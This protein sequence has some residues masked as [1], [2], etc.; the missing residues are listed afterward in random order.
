MTT[1]AWKTPFWPEGVARTISDYHYPLARILDNTA[2]KYPE[3]TFT[4]F[5]GKARTYAQAKDTANRVANFLAR[6]GIRKGDRVALFLP[7]IPQ[8]PEIFFGILKVGAVC[9]NC[10]P[11]YTAAELNH[12]LGDSGARMI[13]CMDHPTLYDTA[14]AAID[15]TDVETV[16]I[17][18]IKSYLPSAQ[19]FIGGLL[20]KIP[21]ASTH[22]PG[23]LNFDDIVA[24][25]APTPPLVD[26]DPEKDTAVMLYTGGTTGTPKGAELT[27]TNF[28]YDL[29]AAHEFFQIDHG[30]GESPEPFRPGGEHTIVGVL[31][32][33]HSFGLTGAMLFAVFSGNKLICIPD[34]RAGKPAFTGLLK[35]VVKHKPTFMPGVPTLFVAITNHP[36]LKKYDL[37]TIKACISAGAP[38]PP[39]VCR[40]FEEKTGAVLFEVY[41][42]TETAPCVTSNPATKE[43]RKVGSI[44]FPI[45]GTDV[46]IVDIDTGT[47]ILPPGEEGELAVCGP[48]VMKG[49]WKRPDANA[50]TFKTL[51]GK[52]YFLTGDI[53]RID[54]NGYIS[55]TDRKKDMIIVSGFN[56]YPREIEDILYT[57][58]GVALAA[59][60]GVPD[61]T[62]G[63][64]V[65]AFIK[66][67]PEHIATQE[68][69]IL[70]CKDKMA[71]YKRPRIVE[72]TDDIPVSSVGKV[73]RRALKEKKQPCSPLD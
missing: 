40:Q 7:N 22:L 25:A 30:Q 48:Q 65:K 37:S 69:I 27:H 35:A 18:N 52:R 63:E 68:E 36:H 47:I 53:G 39:E 31:P 33:Y 60:V 64:T 1:T 3:H 4:L 28:T 55:I 6:Y 14:V 46:K 20:G 50:E 56:V 34:P 13:F 70:F 45:P 9:V 41:G 42:L 58:P 21:K 72:F 12:Q 17:C 10:N 73:L 2:Q 62:R 44:G 8:F 66:L 23:H 5:N 57:Y 24:D 32:W 51:D 16:V 26:I 54:E 67:K 49:Y 11:M 71:G 19:A 43:H 38:M 15:Q 61:E 59:V 29:K